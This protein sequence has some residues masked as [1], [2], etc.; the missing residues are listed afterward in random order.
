MTDKE[1]RGG[2]QGLR[3]EEISGIIQS[4]AVM[5]S[6]PSTAPEEAAAW[7]CLPEVLG[8]TSWVQEPLLV[9]LWF[10]FVLLCGGG[11]SFSPGKPGP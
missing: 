1:T 5:H 2:K 6:L 4:P 7:P 3:K 9:L 10:G 11:V 8:V